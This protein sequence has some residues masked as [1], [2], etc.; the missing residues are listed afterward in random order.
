MDREPKNS[1]NDNEE[2]GLL[3]SYERGEWR[4]IGSLKKKLQQYESYATAALESDGLVSIILLNEDLTAIRQKAT[5]AGMS[6]RMF[7]AKILHEF[8]SGHLFEKPHSYGK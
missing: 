4:S 7:I 5:E 3:A 6:N 2:K 1:L 8:A